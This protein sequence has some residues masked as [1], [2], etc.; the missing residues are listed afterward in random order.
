MLP[1]SFLPAI[2]FTTGSVM[3]ARIA[4]AKFPPRCITRNGRPKK[5]DAFAESGSVIPSLLCIAATYSY[6]AARYFSRSCQ[7]FANSA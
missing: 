7:A 2:R 5:L 6:A 3:D 4:S 1:T